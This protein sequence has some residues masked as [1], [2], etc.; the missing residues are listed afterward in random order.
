MTR[1]DI[2]AMP[3]GRE[4]DALVAE[5]AMGWR[6]WAWSKNER[7]DDG[8]RRERVVRGLRGPEFPGPRWEEW[9]KDGGKVLRLAD[10]SEQLERIQGF[11]DAMSLPIIPEY[12]TDIA[13]AWKVALKVSDEYRLPFFC[14]KRLGK[15]KFQADL[16]GEPDFVA[17]GRT[18]PL[19]ICRAALLVA[20]RRLTEEEKGGVV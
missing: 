14:V 4:L 19:A 3:A 2:L 16:T 13:A 15:K 1:D 12:S 6:W 18:A 7:D 20:D 9:A 8:K 10:G 11:G 5:K 17:S